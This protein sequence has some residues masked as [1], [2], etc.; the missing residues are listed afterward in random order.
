MPQ[1]PSPGTRHP[2]PRSVC[3]PGRKTALRGA[4]V[5]PTLHLHRQPGDLASLEV[6]PGPQGSGPGARD[7]PQPRPFPLPG[8]PPP[9]R[10]AC[11]R[12]R[13]ELQ[14]TPRQPA[15]SPPAGPTSRGPGED[16]RGL[17]QSGGLQPKPWGE[18]QPPGDAGL[19][20]AEGRAGQGSSR[21]PRLAYSAGPQ[22]RA[23]GIPHAVRRPPS[24]EHKLP[25]PPVPGCRPPEPLG[26]SCLP[27]RQH[28][29]CSGCRP[30]HRQDHGLR[31]LHLSEAP[32]GP[33]ERWGRVPEQ[34]WGARA[35]L[36]G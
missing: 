25:H 5:P 2:G 36:P 33:Q 27:G 10:P 30:G 14:P 19:Q 12:S 4:A 13:S 17:E 1:P 26:A 29:T 32:P 23:I 24:P 8:R 11:C 21:T 34:V 3:L 28:P 6:S 7:Q 18:R 16:A 35:H 20:A 31:A 9:A 22:Q 15:R